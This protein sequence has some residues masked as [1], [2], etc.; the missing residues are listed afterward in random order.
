[1]KVAV[2]GAGAAGL[3]AAGKLC[4]RGMEVSVFDGNEKPGKKIYI[5]GKGRCN[6]TNLCLPEDFL[7]NVV[8][9]EKFMFS[10]IYGFT[11]Q[12]L[13][14]LIE[15]E[16]V[17]L[18][19]ERGNRVFPESDKSSDVI[20]ALKR[21]ANEAEFFWGEKV[22]AV[23]KIGDCF[24]VTTSKRR[25]SCDRVVIAT[26]GMSYSATGSRGDGYGFA[27]KFGHRIVDLRPSLI[28]IKLKDAFCK[29]FEGV[30]LKNVKLISV[31]DGKRFEEFGE[32]IFTADGISGPIVLTLSSQ[33]NRVKNVSELY[34]DF[35]PA[36]SLEQLGARLVREFENVKNR[37]I[38]NVMLTLLP[39]KIVS[40]FLGVCKIAED[41]KVNSITK[42]E[43]EE[44]V[45]RLKVFPLKYDK[46]YDIDLGVVTSGG[47]E[48]S[49]VNPKT[50]E[51]KLVKGLYIVGEVLD[52]DALTGG[53][54]LQIAFSTGFAAGS[55]IQ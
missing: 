40:S 37:D 20:S 32:M 42:Q 49:E 33:I 53:F 4:E 2:I 51:S 34:I 9:G 27:K 45:K 24:T 19:V 43:R 18:K 15:A 11:P 7:K 50:M 8:R 26:G 1:M 22:T 31:V 13:F 29:S 38:K 16:G 28:P 25:V 52:V 10:S 44:I 36:L 12:Q 21:Y 30:S 35:K 6:V 5:T 3:I 47:V 39:S 54:N 23:E 17:D 55:Y 46:L 14:E 48:L 41:K